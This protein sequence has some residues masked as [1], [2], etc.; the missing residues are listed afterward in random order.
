V[1]K[2]L[3]V[4]GFSSDLGGS[5]VGVVGT[6]PFSHHSSHSPDI[7]EIKILVSFATRMR[8]KLWELKTQFALGSGIGILEF[9][10]CG[11]WHPPFLHCRMTTGICPGAEELWTRS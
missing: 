5:S 1:R 2:T 10:G 3:G 11:A 9:W 6:N 7:G 8:K 4:A